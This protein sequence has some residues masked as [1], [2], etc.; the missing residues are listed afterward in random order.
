MRVALKLF[1]EGIFIVLGKQPIFTVKYKNKYKAPTSCL[2]Y[3]QFL[4]NLLKMKKNKH[5]PIDFA[6]ASTAQIHHKNLI[7]RSVYLFQPDT[8]PLFQ[9]LI[10]ACIWTRTYF[11]KKTI[12]ISLTARNLIMNKYPQIESGSMG[13]ARK[14]V[15]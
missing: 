15:K 4:C 12:A 14:Y 9:L 2:K 6:F 3:Y 13:Y 11:A 1:I 5:L 10:F 7:P 8:K